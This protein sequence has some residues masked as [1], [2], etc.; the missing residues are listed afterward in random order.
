MGFTWEELD[1]IKPKN[2]EWNIPLPPTCAR[3]GYNLTGLRQRR[4]PEC[5]LRFEW[6]EVRTRMK[7]IWSRANRLR[8]ANR[9]ARFGLI[10]GAAGWGLLLLLSLSGWRFCMF[11]L[12]LL[13]TAAAAF[14]LGAQVL[15]ITRLPIWARDILGKDRPKLWLGLTAMGL[16]ASMVLGLIILP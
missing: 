3:C 2:A 14:V 8:H 6:Q 15:N 10:C 11:D 13:A 4:C 12:I 5:G 16:G 1:K 9:D 7:Q